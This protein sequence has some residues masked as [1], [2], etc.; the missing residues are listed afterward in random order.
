MEQHAQVNN[1]QASN[2][3]T[4]R[5]PL[6][7]DWVFPIVFILALAVFG[8]GVALAAQ[9]RGYELL[10]AGS[11]CL[12]LVLSAWPLALGLT[13]KLRAGR[14]ETAVATEVLRQ[15]LARIEAVTQLISENQLISDR[16]KT[17]AYR[18]RDRDALRR[19]LQEDI[20]RRDWEAASVLV[21]QMEA[22]FGYRLEA[23][24]YRRQIRSAQDEVMR[25]EVA[26]VVA[27]IDR[28]AK[29]EEWDAA[30]TEADQLSRRFPEMPE[31]RNI[32]LDVEQRRNAF[33]QRLVA[34][35]RSAVDRR[36]NDTAL[37]L[38]RRLDLYLSPAEAQG[39]EELARGVVKER[40]A[41]LRQQFTDAVHN[42]DWPRAVSLGDTIVG[43]FP[44]T[45]MAKEVSQ[46]M[47]TLRRRL[48]EGAETTPQAAV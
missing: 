24:E 20:R 19:A 46:K 14:D 16:A 10:A 1:P 13:S 6:S 27:T 39:L 36:D 32:R 4:G 33:K 11:V 3:S 44:N 22:L 41:L 35:F 48:E 40:I 15:Q 23:E 47:P 25:R 43:E 17:V 34:E 18:D 37:E 8:F 9:D 5:K 28:H 30:M 26:E 38:L 2:P 12:V 31:V 7:L 29:A 21:Q 45:L 42:Q